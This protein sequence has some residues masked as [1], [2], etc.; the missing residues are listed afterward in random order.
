MKT[1][2]QTVTSIMEIYS[3][4]PPSIYFSDSS[5]KKSIVSPY[6][7]FEKSSNLGTTEKLMKNCTIYKRT[8]HKF[9]ISVGALE[10]IRIDRVE[11]R[12]HAS[13]GRLLTE[14]A[15]GAP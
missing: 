14:C 12:Q 6:Q 1:R 5:L 7:L 3:K 11:I 15:G 10:M 4:G 2:N 9:S 8:L 13:F